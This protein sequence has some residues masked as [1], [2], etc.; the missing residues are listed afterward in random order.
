MRIVKG[1]VLM[2]L[3]NG[4]GSIT[5][6]KRK[7]L[8]K[9]YMVRV[10]V[11]IEY[12]DNGK[13]KQK[14]ET[15]GYFA[16]KDEAMGALMNFN[17]NEQPKEGLVYKK[18]TFADMWKM[19]IEDKNMSGLAD[20][21]IRGYDFGY[22]LVSDEIKNSKFM[23]LTLHDYQQNCNQLAAEGKGYQTLRKFRST[24]ASVY[25]YANK[26]NIT[27]NNPSQFIDIG[28]SPKKGKTL[29]F[30][31]K[32]IQLLWKQYNTE[33]D[34]GN[35][36]GQET[37][38]IMLM[39]IYNGCR[40]SEFLDLKKENVHLDKR[41]F[42]VVDAKTEAGV[43]QVPIHNGLLNFYQYFYDTYEHEYL[44]SFEKVLKKGKTQRCKYT[45]ANF[46]DSY[47]DPMI[48]LLN[49]NEELTP[50]NARKTCSSLLK[51]A[52]VDATYQKLILGHEG[53]LNLTE[54]VYTAVPV[55]DLV[56][57]INQIEIKNL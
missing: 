2:R 35:L 39:L 14:R 6:I 32:E 25:L 9:P 46:R 30:Q 53:A 55:E 4:Y 20:A 42:D 23:T 8:R 10:T 26:N 38:M 29:I 43:R 56:E 44:L 21:T 49:L 27:R 28:K 1:E 16:T 33:R 45:Y 34:N 41:Y 13:P 51:H 12:D 48:K 50:H 5:K 18:Y 3:P 15:L 31:D 54:K 57:A 52:K 40:I 47:W 37:L 36:K 19:F 22:N 7:N 17:Q 11:G 24:I